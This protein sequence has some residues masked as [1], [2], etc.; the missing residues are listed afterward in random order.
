MKNAQDKNYR[1]GLNKSIRR[2]KNHLKT[3]TLILAF[4]KHFYKLMPIIK[5]FVFQENNFR[6]NNYAKTCF[7]PVSMLWTTMNISFLTH[8]FFNDFDWLN[9]GIGLDKWATKYQSIK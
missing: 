4:P 5:R 3:K 1:V 8:W 2:F 9:M 7:Q 6:I